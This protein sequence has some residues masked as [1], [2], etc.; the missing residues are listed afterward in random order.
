MK[1]RN[2]KFINNIVKI[3]SFQKNYI[4]VYCILSNELIKGGNRKIKN[5]LATTMANG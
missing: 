4:F 2:K 5:N 3:Q 1:I